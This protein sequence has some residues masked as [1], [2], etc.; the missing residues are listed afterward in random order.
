MKNI[1]FLGAGAIGTALGNSLAVRPDLNVNLLSIEK[2][3]VETITSLHINQKYF[4]NIRLTH[5][6]KAT[7]DQN[8]LKDADV[9]FIAIPSVAVVDYMQLIRLLLPEKAILINLAKGFGCHDQII[10]QCLAEHLPNPVCAL[11][12]PS[13]AREIV[14]NSPTAFTLASTDAELCRLLEPLFDETNIFVDTTTDLL[15]VEIVSILKNIYAILIGIVDAHFNSPNLR[16]MMFTRAFN[17][18]RKILIHFGGH[19]ETMFHYCGIGD[20]GLTALNDLSRNRT[21]GLLI[22]K[23]FFNEG[24]PNK[25]VLE[26]RIAMSIILKKLA[27]SDMPET[28]YHMMLQLDKVFAGNTDI[29]EFVNKMINERY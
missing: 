3:V 24:I 26:G 2:D 20:F 23:G 9:V 15:G 1:V 16:F 14:N 29:A 11:K 4:P 10:S 6:L 5:E 22:G 18:M 7:T 28:G 19:E 21:L 8:I 27:E 12:G 13:F 25:V 17:E